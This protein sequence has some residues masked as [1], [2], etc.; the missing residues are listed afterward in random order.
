MTVTR[1]DPLLAREDHSV[2]TTLDLYPNNRSK[3]YRGRLNNSTVVYSTEPM[4]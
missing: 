1:N 2:A 4:L 3:K